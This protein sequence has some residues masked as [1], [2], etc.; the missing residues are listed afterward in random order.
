[1]Y[2]NYHYQDDIYKLGVNLCASG[3][4]VLSSVASEYRRSKYNKIDALKELWFQFY[5]ASK[6]KTLIV[7][8]ASLNVECK[9]FQEITLG[10]LIMFIGKL[11][12]A[13]HNPEK[14]SLIYHDGKY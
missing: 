14:Q 4:S 3:Q 13:I 7:K 12:D 10:D 2:Y 11:L 5:D 8:G 1:L 9:L 6:I